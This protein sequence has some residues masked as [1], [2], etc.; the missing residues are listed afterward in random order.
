[1]CVEINAYK[2]VDDYILQQNCAYCSNMFFLGTVMVIE[3]N[4]QKEGPRRTSLHPHRMG[5]K[6]IHEQLDRNIK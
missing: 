3:C 2:F 4:S 6:Q 1:M 5:L